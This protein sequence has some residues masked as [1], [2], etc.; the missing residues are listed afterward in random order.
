[1]SNNIL[2][3]C[4][5]ENPEKKI[6]ENLTKF[7]LNE[8]TIITCAYCTTIYGIYKEILADNDL[9]TFNLVKNIETNKEDLKDFDRSDFSE[10][11]MFFDYDGHATNASDSKLFD[12]LD[13]FNEETEK[14]KLY[15]SY[16]MAE[17][18]KHIENLVTF[19]YLKYSYKENAV[20]KKYVKRNCLEEFKIFMNYDFSIWK[21]L[22][23]AH[24]SKMNLIVNDKYEFPVS[25]INQGLIF[26]NQLNKF[27][28]IDSTVSVLSSFPPFLHDYYGN[29]KFVEILKLDE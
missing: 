22:I 25:I 6:I 18:L 13:F 27:I 12:L 28:N 21:I 20:Y 16:P 29:K 17:A 5:G 14:G 3:I 9:D 4:E 11:Y 26:V 15:I 1:M 10:I 7:F 2:F 19:N 24:L 23:V 8:N